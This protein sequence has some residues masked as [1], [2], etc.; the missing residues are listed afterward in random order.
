MN[1]ITKSEQFYKLN[2]EVVSLY[3][4]I[5]AFNRYKPKN[6]QR[7]K[8]L[9]EMN[10]DQLKYSTLHPDFDRH[11]IRY[12]IDDIKAELKEIKAIESDFSVL[13]RDIRKPDIIIK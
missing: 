8:G 7:Y 12:T 1:I 6:I 2:G 4:L 9:G 10:A 5:K 3:D 13:L 11:L